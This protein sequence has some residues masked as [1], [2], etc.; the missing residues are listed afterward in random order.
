MLMD[1]ASIKAAEQSR[2]KGLPMWPTNGTAAGAR[3]SGQHWNNKWFFLFKS[4]VRDLF[5]EETRT[6]L[7]HLDVKRWASHLHSD[8]PEVRKALRKGDDLTP[9]HLKLSF[10]R[11][12][13]QDSVACLLWL[14]VDQMS[15]DMMAWGKL[16]VWNCWWASFVSLLKLPSSG[17]SLSTKII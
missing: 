2:N 17:W 7:S 12:F 14:P 8:R 6:F 16:Q 10:L 5:E 15:P 13:L 4:A 3:S 11:T 9:H 1:S